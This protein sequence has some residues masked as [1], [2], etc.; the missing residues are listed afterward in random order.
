MGDKPEFPRPLSSGEDSVSKRPVRKTDDWLKWSVV[1]A[2]VFLALLVAFLPRPVFQIDRVEF[3]TTSCDPTSHSYQVT[4]SMTIR[5]AGGAP[6]VASVHL[7]ADGHIAA[8]GSYEVP[9]HG[10]IQR[11]L[12]AIIADCQWHQFSMELFVPP[13]A[14][15]GLLPS[16]EG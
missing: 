16:S 5:N 11:G 7:L 9:A 12:S 1:G 15:A 3:V 10:T 2:L 6:G 4:A 8:T 14:V 13:D